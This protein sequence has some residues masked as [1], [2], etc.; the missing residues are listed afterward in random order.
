MLYMLRVASSQHP[1]QSP[2]R[3]QD[4]ATCPVPMQAQA[5]TTPH[6]QEAAAALQAKQAAVWHGL[7]L[8]LPLHGAGSMAGVAGSRAQ[9]LGL[10]SVSVTAGGQ[11]PVLA[12]AVLWWAQEADRCCRCHG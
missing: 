8:D 2:A 3:Q 11:L 6:S 5:N 4:P 9:A 7:G 10:G 1:T 12:A